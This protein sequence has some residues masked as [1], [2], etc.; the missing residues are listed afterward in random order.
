MTAVD[1]Y[2]LFQPANSSGKSASPNFRSDLSACLGGYIMPHPQLSTPQESTWDAN[3][4]WAPEVKS[5]SFKELSSSK[6]GGPPKTLVYRGKSHLWMM[7]RG[8]PQWNLH[9]TGD[10]LGASGNPLGFPWGVEERVRYGR[11]QRMRSSLLTAR[12]PPRP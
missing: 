1:F 3:Q 9:F 11:L 8:F 7:T 6:N 10:F 12:K 5:N 2:H 4:R